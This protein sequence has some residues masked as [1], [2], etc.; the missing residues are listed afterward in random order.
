MYRLKKQ[1]R[2]KVIAAVTKD[3]S[4]VRIDDDF[5]NRHKNAKHLIEGDKAIGHFFETLEGA[6]VNDA[7]KPVSE[8]KEESKPV[9]KAKAK[10]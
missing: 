7:P 10:K 6:P 9:T 4:S 8:E 3:G 1:Y 5:F 2:K